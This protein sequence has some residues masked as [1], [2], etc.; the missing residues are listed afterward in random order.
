MYVSKW[1]RS[2][3]ITA[4]GLI[5]ALVSAFAAILVVPEVRKVL[6]L[7]KV[8]VNMPEVETL[9][10]DRDAAMK[11]AHNAESLFVGEAAVRMEVEKKLDSCRG[12]PAPGDWQSGVECRNVP[13]D[14]N[15]LE[16]LFT[17]IRNSG[18]TG[19]LSRKSTYV[20]YV[21]LDS[22]VVYFVMA[23]R[24]LGARVLVVSRLPVYS[25]EMVTRLDNNMQQA[26]RFLSK[27]VQGHETDI[28]NI[29]AGHKGKIYYT[30]TEGAYS[31]T[32]VDQKEGTG[33]LKIPEGAQSLRLRMGAYKDRT[34]TYARNS[35]PVSFDLDGS[36]LTTTPSLK[37]DAEDFLLCTIYAGGINPGTHA[38]KVGFQYYQWCGPQER[39]KYWFE[40]AGRSTT[41]PIEVDVHGNP[42]PSLRSKAISELALP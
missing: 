41:S 7:D 24:G 33:Y 11:S 16:A 30:Q 22:D 1:S 4:V 32:Y 26:A 25:V 18:S 23:Q 31:R 27:S 34:N 40:C 37:T 12:I 42:Q 15:A 28:F 3:K 20:K 21:A 17:A 13:L 10:R 36:T 39:R 9:R 6:G 38:Y 8:I 5:I 35:C 2:E 29:F 19:E 14:D